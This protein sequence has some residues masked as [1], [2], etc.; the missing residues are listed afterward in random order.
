[1][2]QREIR[3]QSLLGLKNHNLGECSQSPVWYSSTVNRSKDL[4]FSSLQKWHNP[5]L[6]WNSSEFGG[7]QSIQTNAEKIWVPD[8]LV[9]NK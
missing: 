1:M 6:E 4:M 3:I 9:Y 2:L 8:V 5:F 7:I